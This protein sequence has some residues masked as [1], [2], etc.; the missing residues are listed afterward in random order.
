MTVTAKRRAGTG[1]AG[2][3]REA[4]RQAARRTARRRRILSWAVPAVV[5]VGLAAAAIAFSGGG[6]GPTGVLPSARGSVTADGPPREVPLSRGEVVPA[7]IAPGLGGGTVS[8]ADREGRPTVLAVWA[9]WCPVCQAELPVLGRVAAD[10]PDVA[11]ITVVTSIGDRPGPDAGEFLE[12]NGL[13]FTTAIDDEDGILA[14]A[15]GIQGF[16]TLYVVGPDGVVLV[17]G[18]GEVAEDVLRDVFAELEALV[19]AG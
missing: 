18:T 7:F 8:W 14:R 11:V 1:G 17:A 15:L 16:P 3:R 2:S 12:E 13:D 6:G 5:V 19:P 4:A 9:P 10:H